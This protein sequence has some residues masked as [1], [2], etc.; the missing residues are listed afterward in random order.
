[1]KKK[2]LL[3][4]VCL[5]FAVFG[6]LAYF[7]YTDFYRKSVNHTG[8][9][10]S[11]KIKRVM[12]FDDVRQ[13]LLDDGVISDKASFDRIAAV[14]QYNQSSIKTGHYLIPVGI[15]MSKLI[16]ILK[17]GRQTPIKYTFNNLRT[18]NDFITH[19]SANFDFTESEMVEILFNQEFLDSNNVDSY[20]LMS[21]FI[22]DTYEVYYNTSA[23]NLVKKLLGYHRQFWNSNG[24]SEKAREL[25]LTPAEV[26]TLASIVEKETNHNDERPRIAGVYL[27]RLR[28]GM[29]L[30]AD[31]TVVFATGEYAL[32]RVLNEHLQI[33]SPYNTYLYFGLPPGPIYMPSQ[34]SIDAV[35]N[36]EKHDLLYFCAAPGYNSRHLF[37]GTFD[38]HQRNAMTYRKWLNNERIR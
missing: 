11:L 17:T 33:D 8:Q 24:R 38:Q 13:K 30:Q 7:L 14:L 16:K 23:Q 5:M 20:S 31:P 26:Y 28:K 32:R 18:I 37:A 19:A 21:L 1:M 29:K 3:M 35:L 27:N 4:G 12:G 6:A 25:G 34:S 9:V 15:S 2:L 10:Y 22:P 36:Y